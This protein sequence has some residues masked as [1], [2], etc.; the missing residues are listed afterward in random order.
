MQLLRCARKPV[1]CGAQVGMHF[2]NPVPGAWASLPCEVHPS[3]V[4]AIPVHAGFCAM[5]CNV[6]CARLLR[7]ALRV[8]V[9]CASPLAH[10]KLIGSPRGAAA[11]MPLVEI[12][13]GIATSDAVR[14][15]HADAMLPLAGKGFSYL[16]WLHQAL[17]SWL[18]GC[19]SP[20]EGSP[21][22]LA[23]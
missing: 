15:Q 21:L 19:G 23:L 9:G 5:R 8:H 11:V 1:A 17:C 16:H 3:R 6:A 2:M 12:I 10:A 20:P 4:L 22:P 7:L 13:R 18:H 14:A